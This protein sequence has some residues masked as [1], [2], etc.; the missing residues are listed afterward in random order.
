MDLAH[1]AGDGSDPI[2]SAARRK[3]CGGRL[4]NPAA[5]FAGVV[6]A[7][8]LLAAPSPADDDLGAFTQPAPGAPR[9]WQGGY[10]ISPYST[11]NLYNGNVLT[12]IP[13]VSYDPVGPPV[14]LTLYHNS[15]DANVNRSGA[16]GQGFDLGRGWSTSYSG[17]IEH[18]PNAMTCVV[19]EDDGTRNTYT[20]TGGVWT[21]PTSVYDALT[22][23]ESLPD[24]GVYYWR[25]TRTSQTQ[26]IFDENGLLIE[27][28]DSSGNALKIARDTANGG[29]ITAIRSAA[30]GLTVP[31]SNP[32][33]T[34]DHEL[35]FTYADPNNP[36]RLRRVTDPI[37]RVWRFEYNTGAGRL[38]KLHYP[39]DNSVD[40]SYMEFAYAAAK[41]R[42]TRIHARREDT[43]T[44][45]IYWDYKYSGGKL[46]QVI[47]PVQA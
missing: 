28:R 15:A 4:R 16:A 10:A 41:G 18:D 26:R 17:R 12:E 31:G 23:F 13:I 5:Q 7:S 14:S 9:A 6:V 34:I 20:K 39:S 33:V 11:Y 40:P 25:L 47:D 46:T 19:I 43:D 35:T 42:I 24:S 32:P 30:D 37:G 3:P 2:A 38:S 27:I 21:P 22:R 45:D 8:L 1:Y 44:N 36:D 29:R